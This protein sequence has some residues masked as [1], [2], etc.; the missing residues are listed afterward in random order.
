[1]ENKS[2]ANGCSTSKKIGPKPSVTPKTT[3][4]IGWVL[5]DALKKALKKLS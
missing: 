3:F 4:F 1:M 2:L 5:I